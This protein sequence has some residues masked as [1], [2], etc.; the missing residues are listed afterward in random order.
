MSDLR[1]LGTLDVETVV[2][3][4]GAPILQNAAERFRYAFS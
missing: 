3:G 4:H 2:F 1:R